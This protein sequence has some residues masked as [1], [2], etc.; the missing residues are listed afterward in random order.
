MKIRNKPLLF[1]VK[2]CFWSIFGVW[3]LFGMRTGF[4]YDI[5]VGKGTEQGMIADDSVPIAKSKRDVAQAF[6]KHTPL[7]ISK[8]GLIQAPLLR[9]RDT[10]EAGEHRYKRHSATRTVI[11]DEFI[12]TDTDDFFQNLLIKCLGVNYY[13]RY[14]VAPLEDGSYVLVYFDDYLLGNNAPMPT[15]YVRSGLPYEQRTAKALQKTYNIDSLYV[16]DM[17]RHGKVSNL[18]DILLRAGIGLAVFCLVTAICAYI[19]K[20]RAKKGIKVPP[21]FMFFR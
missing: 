1:W 6:L 19:K 5:G 11:V 21:Y 9:L 13:N 18:V 20:R 14:Y 2:L 17:Y 4:F 12:Q 3:I 7:T 16:L 10:D 15:G 8:E